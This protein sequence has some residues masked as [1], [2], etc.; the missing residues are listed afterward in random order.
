MYCL[1][2][3]VVLGQQLDLQRL[4]TDAQPIAG[5]EC[6]LANDTDVRPKPA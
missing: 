3:A 6:A 1:T 2:M 4:L 5:F